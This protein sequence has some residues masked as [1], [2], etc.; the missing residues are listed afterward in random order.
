MLRSLMI[1]TIYATDIY[2]AL[3]KMKKKY[4]NHYLVILEIFL[5]AVVL[6][7]FGEFK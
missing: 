7:I 2:F 1:Y 6:I 5:F 4:G 3:L